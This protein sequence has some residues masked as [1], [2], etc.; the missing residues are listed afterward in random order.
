VIVFKILVGVLKKNTCQE[1]NKKDRHC[2][3]DTHL[4]G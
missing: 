1:V 2:L 4:A 3:V